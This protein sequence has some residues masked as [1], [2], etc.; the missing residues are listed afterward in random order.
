MQINLK[1]AQEMK[2]AI[3]EPQKHLFPDWEWI[4][5]I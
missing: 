1:D 3:I 5:I 2:D 4:S